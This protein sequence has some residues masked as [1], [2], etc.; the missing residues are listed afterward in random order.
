MIYIPLN[1]F[2]NMHKHINMCI[3]ININLLCGIQRFSNNNKSQDKRGGTITSRAIQVRQHQHYFDFKR[4]LKLK[5][6]SAFK[7]R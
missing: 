1:K 3:Y 5:Y 6:I 7:E 4:D 2:Q